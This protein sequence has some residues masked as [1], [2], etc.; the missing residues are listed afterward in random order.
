MRPDF[1]KP[2]DFASE[3]ARLRELIR[4]RSYREGDF[5]L[6]SGK[7]SGFYIDMK[8]T[9]L[10]AEGAFLLGRLSYDLI[11]RFA[12]TRFPAAPGSGVQGVGGLTMGADPIA[13]AV[14]LS[15]YAQGADWPAFIVRKETKGH[16]TGRFVEG[17]E[18][19]PA[20]AKV[21]VLEDVVTTGGSSILAIERLRAE[22]Y[23]PVAVL[24]VVDREEGGEAALKATGLEFL[25]LL[26]I[27]EIRGD[28]SR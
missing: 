22:G 14:S 12:A 8:A 18:N 20:G 19:L 7:K 25:R 27:S 1:S 28:S 4:E 5:T 26:T 9:T 15:A 24:T 16:G 21:V 23:D 10:S 2:I 3:S 11:K 6:A 13:T 17:R